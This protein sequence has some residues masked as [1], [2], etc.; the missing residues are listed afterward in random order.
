MLPE[1]RIKSGGKFDVLFLA[2]TIALAISSQRVMPPKIFIIIAFVLGNFINLLKACK[3]FSSLAPPP[4]SKK[5][6][7]VADGKRINEMVKKLLG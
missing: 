6:A 4:I 5:F 7:G 2:L 1:R 3:T